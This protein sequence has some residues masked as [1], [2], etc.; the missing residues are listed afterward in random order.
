MTST[1]N[2]RTSLT[3]AVV[4]ASVT[5]AS[6]AA[7]LAG[8]AVATLSEQ[9]TPLRRVELARL[10]AAAIH[11]GLPSDRMDAAVG[12]VR[13][14]NVIVVVVPAEGAAFSGLL[15]AF[16]AAVPVESWRGKT[17][18][19][20]LIGGEPTALARFEARLRSRFEA[21]GA[22]VALGELFDADDDFTGFEADASLTARV[23][24]AIVEA[25][26]IPQPLP[27]QIQADRVQILTPVLLAS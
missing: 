17:I 11:D 3:A 20:L 19:P 6:R 2:P 9:G 18:V 25:L 21:L 22:R 7:I 15:P 12:A 23:D 16:L 4:S 10:P 26:P 8:C 13:S 1:L 14:S 24:R 5:P 27:L